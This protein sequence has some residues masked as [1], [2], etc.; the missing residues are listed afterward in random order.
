MTT[1]SLWATMAGKPIK[2][3]V[4]VAQVMPLSSQRFKRGTDCRRNILNKATASGKPSVDYSQ[5]TLTEATVSQLNT[6]EIRLQEVSI[7]AYTTHPMP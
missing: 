1:G 6:S 2:D 5:S 7:L 4:G 3:V